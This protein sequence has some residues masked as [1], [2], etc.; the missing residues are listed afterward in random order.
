ME[1]SEDFQLRAGLGE[2]VVPGRN[3]TPQSVQRP[4]KKCSQ[5]ESLS[6]RAQ[7]PRVPFSGKPRKAHRIKKTRVLKRPGSGSRSGSE[8]QVCEN[9]L[10][11]ALTENFKSGICFFL[12]LCWK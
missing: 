6:K 5:G 4:G 10:G 9:S 11:F 8:L 2:G 12:A 7:S 3:P 1:I